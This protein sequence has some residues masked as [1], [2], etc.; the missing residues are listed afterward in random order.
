VGKITVRILGLDSSCL[1]APLMQKTARRVLRL[2]NLSGEFEIIAADLA[3]MRRLNRIYRR[4]NR[5]TD[6]L[7]FSYFRAMPHAK[8]LAR[9][10]IFIPAKTFKNPDKLTRLMV[11][12]ILHIRGHSHDTASSTK[13]MER[14]E[15]RILQALTFKNPKP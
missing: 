10:Q 9:G 3:L 13:R 4:K 2:L 12:A 5:L 14:E 1:P 8:N 11:H 6:V 7:A 15:K